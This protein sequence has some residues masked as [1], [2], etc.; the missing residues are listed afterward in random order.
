MLET[1]HEEGEMI[2]KQEIIIIGVMAVFAVVLVVTVLLVGAQQ[3]RSAA[4]NDDRIA[5]YDIDDELR[6]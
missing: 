3:L 2:V 1:A 4:W 5:F 6:G